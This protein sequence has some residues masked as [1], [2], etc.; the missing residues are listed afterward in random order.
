MSD[1]SKLPNPMQ[2]YFRAQQ[3]EIDKEQEQFQEKRLKEKAKEDAAQKKLDERAREEAMK[4]PEQK[5]W[6][7]FFITHFNTSS[8]FHIFC[9]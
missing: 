4:S 1:N 7:L 9:S 8:L 2:E 6:S 5:V 3:R